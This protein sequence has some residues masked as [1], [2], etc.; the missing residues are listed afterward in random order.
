MART[1]PPAERGARA[2]EAL[3]RLIEGGAFLATYLL[4][5]S[6]LIWLARKTLHGP[7]IVELILEGIE[8]FSALGVAGLFILHTI[9]VLFEY[10]RH[11]QDE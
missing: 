3:V 11:L 9:R 6:G 5:E 2:W 7:P 4:I 1:R 10:Y 8:I